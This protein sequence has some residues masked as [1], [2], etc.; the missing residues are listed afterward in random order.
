M[1]KIILSIAAAMVCTAAWADNVTGEKSF[2]PKLGYYSHNKSAVAGLTF[3]YAFNRHFRL[4][5]EVGCVFRHNDQ[6]AFVADLNAQFPFKFEEAGT[7]ALYPLAGI[8]YT[9]WSRHFRSAEI[10]KDVTTHDNRFGANVGAGF[11]L[12]CSETLRL[13]LEAKY[14]LVK[15]YSSVVVTAGISYVF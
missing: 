12:R 14:V 1:K 6:D 2:G 7:V 9:S 11:E 4:A 8:T 10:D 5:P 15:S 3:T 13:S